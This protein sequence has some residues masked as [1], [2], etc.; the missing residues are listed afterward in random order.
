ME[1]AAARPSLGSLTS[2]DKFR[3]TV[4]EQIDISEVDHVSVAFVPNIEAHFLG[5]ICA[6]VFS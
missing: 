3:G 2:L 5:R 1:I 6:T 4:A